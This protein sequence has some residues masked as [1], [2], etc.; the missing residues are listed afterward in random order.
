[1]GGLGWCYNSFGL[2]GIVLHSEILDRVN[3]ELYYESSLT[4]SCKESIGDFTPI[5]LGVEK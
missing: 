4:G 2:V 3:C 5:V 1:M